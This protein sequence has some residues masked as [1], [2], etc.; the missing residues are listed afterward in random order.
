M[1]SRP[2]PG[3]YAF[4][5]QGPDR[6]FPERPTAGSAPRPVRATAWSAVLSAIA[7]SAVLGTL[8]GGGLSPGENWDWGWPF[9][10]L[11]VPLSL[12]WGV[13]DLVAGR[14]WQALAGGGAVGTAVVVWVLL[15][16]FT[17]GGVL[18]PG[19]WLAGLAGLPLTLVAASSPP[20]RR[21][22]A[23][24]RGDPVPAAR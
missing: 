10:L 4:P 6:P 24:R 16:A 14:N 17:P 5:Y 8:V 20:V 1:R 7:S 18:D 15:E 9:V 13:L 12:L 19:W 21:W 23:W 2:Y 3:P 22:V 11:V